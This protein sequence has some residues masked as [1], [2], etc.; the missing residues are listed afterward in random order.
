M[1][2]ARLQFSDRLGQLS[3]LQLGCKDLET[4]HIAPLTWPPVS[5]GWWAYQGSIHS[6][7]PIHNPGGCF[8][9]KYKIDKK[10]SL[11]IDG[12][13]KVII[14]YLNKEQN[15]YGERF[16]Q[17]FLDRPPANPTTVTLYWARE[18]PISKSNDFDFITL[19]KYAKL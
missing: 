6:N 18:I 9:F 14:Y 2:K 16:C 17:D 10:F 3:D 4:E 5:R 8:S 1:S 19:N 12:I 13:R 7:Y 15:K 11:K